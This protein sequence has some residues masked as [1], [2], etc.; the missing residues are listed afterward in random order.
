M[1]DI[2]NEHWKYGS[3]FQPECQLIH[4]PPEC[5]MPCITWYFNAVC[6][7][8]ARC[9][10]GEQGLCTYNH[11]IVRY[12]DA[13]IIAC[14]KGIPAIIEAI[15]E[16]GI[17]ISQATLME[18]L[19]NATDCGNVDIVR[20]IRGHYIIFEQM[21]QLRRNK[22]MGWQ[23]AEKPEQLRQAGNEFMVRYRFA[24]KANYK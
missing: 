8:N 5:I 11:P 21:P 18:G 17:M 22:F 20:F 7:D 15:Y 24:A 9:E 2:C 13:Y 14:R 10:L 6:K 16:K 19:K 12:D 1:S 4:L 23:R 3:C